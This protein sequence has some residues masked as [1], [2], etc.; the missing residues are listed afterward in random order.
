MLT[1][2]RRLMDW[3]GEWAACVQF[4][5]MAAWYC[6]ALRAGK[7]IQQ[8]LVLLDRPQTLYDI[9]ERLRQQG[10]PAGWY[11]SDLADANIHVP[12]GPIAH[13]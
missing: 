8:V 10:P 9:A 11:E 6:K 2:F 7:A 12:S 3:R 4:R 5:K 13:W 1:H